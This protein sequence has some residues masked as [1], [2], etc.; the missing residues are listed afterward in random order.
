MVMIQV[1]SLNK[2]EWNP[3]VE[4]GYYVIFQTT[5]G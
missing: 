1:N 5:D 2:P 4:R 3:E